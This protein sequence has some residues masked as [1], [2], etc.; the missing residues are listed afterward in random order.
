MEFPKVYVSRLDQFH[1]HLQLAR[2]EL[3]QIE[4]EF[5]QAVEVLILKVCMITEDHLQTK[6]NLNYCVVRRLQNVHSD[7]SKY[8]A[9]KD[10]ELR[11]TPRPRFVQA[12]SLASLPEE[13][14]IS[15]AEKVR[16]YHRHKS[17]DMSVLNTLDTHNLSIRLQ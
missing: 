7:L 9:T 17:L 5:P 8:A 14:A 2:P 3:L 16:C 11:E 15:V 4:G 13:A 1:T 6:G 12:A 10:F